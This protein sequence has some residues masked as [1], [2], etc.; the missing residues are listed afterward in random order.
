MAK[1]QPSADRIV[2]LDQIIPSMNATY[3]D[4]G[5]WGLNNGWRNY[6]RFGV[7]IPYFQTFIDLAGYTRQDNLTFF[8]DDRALLD[9]GVYRSTIGQAGTP[10]YD[11]YIEMVT[12]VT[13]GP[14]SADTLIS[15]FLTSPDGNPGYFDSTLDW[16]QVI[17]GNN[18]ILAVDNEI[19]GQALLTKFRNHYFGSGEPSNNERLYITKFLVVSQA[20]GIADGDTIEIPPCRI[21]L[22]GM[23]A[24]EKE[25]ISVFRLAR[26]Y[27]LNQ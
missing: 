17:L 6:S 5:E 24:E 2:K 27:E 15:E 19:G 23:A 3:L 20:S 25:Y 11:F 18:T 12:L 8:M 4:T 1:K 9:P 13:P 26:S 10:A 14:V 7:D 21:V 22:R 16:N